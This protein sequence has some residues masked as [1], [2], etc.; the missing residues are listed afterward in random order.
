M[1]IAI[2]EVIVAITSFK[3][4]CKSA[5]RSCSHQCSET[6][7]YLLFTVFVLTKLCFSI[8]KLLTSVNEGP[9]TFSK[10]SSSCSQFARSSL[11]ILETLIVFLLSVGL[12]F[13][14]YRHDLL[15]H[16][17]DFMHIIIKIIHIISCKSV[18]CIL[19]KLS[20]SARNALLQS[21]S[22]C[23]VGSH[24]LECI[25][26]TFI[27]ISKLFLTSLELLITSIPCIKA[28]P[29]GLCFLNLFIKHFCNTS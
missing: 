2:I 27:L 14:E 20:I 7:S 4:G 23:A 22:K 21:L 15:E 19:S 8:C 25:W 11:V 26:K 18:T 5:I 24:L 16:G 13:A 28:V 12:Y 10:L 17:C 29:A 9:F 1:T 6:I 3:D